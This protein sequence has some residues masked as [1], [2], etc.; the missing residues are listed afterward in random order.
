MS[1]KS[2]NHSLSILDSRGPGLQPPDA[3]YN[4]STRP[5]LEP[6][7]F[8][9]NGVTLAV[10]ERPGPEPAV[11]YCHA[12]GFHARCWDRIVE[13]VGPHRAVA[14]DMRGHGRSAKPRP[15]IAWRSFG[16]DVAS[17]ARSL[18]LRGAIGVGHSMGGHSLALAAALAPEAFAELILLDPVIIPEASYRGPLSQPHFARKRRNN[19]ES[20]TEMFERFRARSPFDAWD[21]KVLRDY[22][23]FGLLPSSNGGG[24]VLACPPEIEGSIYEQSQAHESNIYSEIA[25]VRIPVSIVRAPRLFK[26]GPAMDMLASPTAPDLASRFPHGRDMVVAGSHFIPMEAPDWVAAEIRAALTRQPRP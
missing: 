19:W 20:P 13:P 16:H 17:L 14:I 24:L 4:K 7:Y 22:C 10:W 3:R 23:E 11:V 26:E 1:L 8:D 6:R 5:S 12:T 21:E 25:Q 15:P 2:F 9:V 18:G